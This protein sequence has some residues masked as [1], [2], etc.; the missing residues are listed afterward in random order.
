MKNKLNFF[1]FKKERGDKIE[2][3]LS[4]KD[5]VS[6]DTVGVK[7]NEEISFELH[8]SDRLYAP[9]LSIGDMEYYSTEKTHKDIFLYQWN[10]DKQKMI[11]INHFGHCKLTIQYFKSKDDSSAINI[12]TII[13]VFAVKFKAEQVKSMLRYL[14]G[15]MDDIAR[16]CFSKTHLNTN[17][18][19]D[20][21]SHAR[22]ILQVA[23]SCLKRIEYNLPRFRHKPVSKLS[24]QEK[25]Q[26][27]N[28]IELI[29]PSSL[30]WLIQNP[31]Q[32]ALPDPLSAH[33]IKVRNRLVGIEA[34]IGEELKEDTDTYEN[35]AIVGLMTNIMNMLQKIRLNYENLLLDKHKITEVPD[36]YESLDAIRQKLY[37]QQI[38]KCDDLQKRCSVC[39]QFWK[40]Y[41][42]TK[43]NIRYMPNLTPKFTSQP[44][45]YEI[46]IQMVEWYR[47]GK[48]NIDGEKYL[49]SL[50]TLDKLY[51][52][53]CLFLILESLEKN[54]WKLWDSITGQSSTDIKQ[55]DDWQVLPKKRYNFYYKNKR[56]T[57]Q[58]EPRIKLAKESEGELVCVGGNSKYLSPDFLLRFF[59]G[60][61]VNYVV[62]DSKYMNPSGAIKQLS[63]KLI[64]KYI[65]RIASKSGG[66]SPVKALFALHPKDIKRSYRGVFCHSYYQKPYDMNS[67]SSII[68]TLGTI[69]V[70][71]ENHELNREGLSKRLN[72]IFS[73]I[74]SC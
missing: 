28:K 20:G 44:H 71:P 72:E 12:S 18:Q 4:E 53:Y 22:A 36:G 27:A 10:F 45:Y 73:F 41:L 64:P 24:P 32:F 16:T 30:E 7:E 63:E 34:M 50:R 58:Y 21:T 9:V 40:Q 51:E 46:F 15:R 52:F 6:K 11:F 59:D 1:L 29:T 5:S 39:L 37:D 13:D 70:T 66:I 65:H 33:T 57:L 25:I 43:K 55:Y 56:I 49:L 48:L 69:E 35:Q 54:N 19:N 38:K 67:D 68:P 31:E 3:S 62:F 23:E 47:L 26:P 61:T 8:S 74:E 14:E 60:K 42:P 17:A 2:L